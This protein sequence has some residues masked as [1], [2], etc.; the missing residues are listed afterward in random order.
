MRELLTPDTK[1]LLLAI[2]IRLGEVKREK[3][4]PPIPL[5]WV[6]SHPIPSPSMRPHPRRG[7]NAI[8]LLV[9]IRETTEPL[10]LERDWLGLLAYRRNWLFPRFRTEES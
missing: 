9:F 5:S 3:S 4:G 2:I 8:R 1:I 10:S 7:W 6:S